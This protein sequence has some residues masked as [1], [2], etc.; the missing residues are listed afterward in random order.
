MLLEIIQTSP[1]MS[2]IQN[3]LIAVEL[4]HTFTPQNLYRV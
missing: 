1:L 2:E 3:L 4:I